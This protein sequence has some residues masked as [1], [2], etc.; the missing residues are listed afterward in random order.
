MEATENAGRSR[1]G[2]VAIMDELEQY[3]AACEFMRQQRNAANDRIVELGVQLEIKA[4]ELAAF[5][6]QQVPKEPPA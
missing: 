1:L 5:E 4:R 6:R 2:N 3:K